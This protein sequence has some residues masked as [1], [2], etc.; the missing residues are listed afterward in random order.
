M[1]THRLAHDVAKMAVAVA[2]L[3]CAA[4]QSGHAAPLESRTLVRYSGKLMTYA[5]QPDSVADCGASYV[6]YDT[7]GYL[8]L[9]RSTRK[10][11]LEGF[12]CTLDVTEAASVFTGAAQPCVIDG[13]ASFQGVGIAELEFES[14]SVDV[15]SRSTSWRARA[16]RSLPDDRRVAYCFGVTGSVE[17]R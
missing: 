1:T 10:A 14:F 2:A 15:G 5:E 16:F 12:G 3:A 11:R 9:D 4:C 6:T 13:P 17:R 7:S 8:V